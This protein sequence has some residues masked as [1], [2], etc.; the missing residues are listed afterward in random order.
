M[1]R[2]TKV[3]IR[4]IKLGRQTTTKACLLTEQYCSTKLYRFKR[5]SDMVSVPFII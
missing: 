3:L 1:L 2:L 4:P 5:P